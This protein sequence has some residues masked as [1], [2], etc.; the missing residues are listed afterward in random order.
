M[1]PKI[2]HYCWFGGAPF[3][4]KERRCIDSWRKYCPDYE[5]REWNET[6]YDISANAYIQQAYVAKRWA[7]VT[8]FVRLDVIYQ[9]G[10]I[11]LDRDVEIFQNLDPLLES[12][13]FSGMENVDGN[14]LSVNTGL[15]FGAVAGNKIIGEWRDIYKN[16]S[17]LSVD[18]NQDLLTTPARITASLQKRGFYQQNS[19]QVI[20][21]M[22]V[23]PT[24]YFS[25]KQYNTQ[26]LQITPNT[27]SIHHY[28]ESWKSEEER[29]AS[30]EWNSLVRKYGHR[31][32]EIISAIKRKIN[33]GGIPVVIKHVIRKLFNHR[34][35][36]WN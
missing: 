16:L 21:E 29:R 22:V 30:E 27:Y 26:K 34:K 1:I 15:G 18:G 35:H 12:Q 4:E 36:K 31:G 6:N 9:Y 20:D 33:E 7:F 14:Q 8:D 19:I 25:P 5:I 10:G 13:A 11:Y 2:I 28:S 32:A 3:S 17:F 23:Y 24:E